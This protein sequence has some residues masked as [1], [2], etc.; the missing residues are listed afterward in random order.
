MTSWKKPT[1]DLVARAIARM[2]FQQQQRYFF[3]HLDNPEWIEPLRKAKFF[4]ELPVVT[5]EEKS[6]THYMWPASRYLARMAALKP[7]LV[8]EI[9]NSFPEIDNPFVIQDILAAADAMPAVSAAKLAPALTRCARG[10]GFIG[11]ERAGRIA[12][13]LAQSEKKDAALVVLRSILEVVPDPRPVTVGPSGHVYRHEARTQIRGFDYGTILRTYGGELASALGS[14]YLEILAKKL[15]KALAEE[16]P[17]Y[18]KAPR[19]VE[20]YSYIWRPHLEHWDMR[21]Q[22]KQFLVFGLLQATERMAAEGQWADAQKVLDNYPFTAYQRVLLFVLAKHPDLDMGLVGK[23]LTDPDLFHALGL[24]QE[25]D[26]LART[27]FPQ[28]SPEVQAAFLALIDAAPDKKQMT[29]R[30]FSDEQIEQICRRWTLE[31]FEPI[32]EGLPPE[33]LKQIEALEQEFGAV[34]KH[35]NH[36]VRGGAVPRGGSSSLSSQDIQELSVDELLSYLRTWTPDRGGNPFGPSYQGLARELTSAIAASPEKYLERLNDFKALQ[37]T[38]VRAAFQGF[39]EATRNGG[40]LAWAPLL[41]LADWICEQPADSRVMTDE[42]DWNGPDRGWHATRFAIVDMLEDALKTNALPP[43]LGDLAWKL[44][45]TL[46][47]DEDSECLAYDEAESQ[48]KDVWT[49]SLNTLRPRAFRVALNYM[50]WLYNTRLKV[51]GA[52]VDDVPDIVTYLDR[53]LD[54]QSDKCLSVR[55]AYG[56][57]LPFL[58]AHAPRWASQAFL[59]IFPPQAEFKPLKDVAWSAYLAANRAYTALF[60]PLEELYREAIHIADADRLQ[61]KSHLQD[62]P[63]SL[64]AHHL[65]QLYWWGKIELAPGG[66][67]NDFLDNV[68]EKALRSAI[69]YVGQ[70]LSEANGAVPDDVISRLQD[71]WDY[72]LAS[73]QSISSPVAFGSFG[74]WFNTQYFNDEWAL[75]HIRRSLL[76]SRGQF[77]PLLNALSRLSNLAN[78]YPA[79]AFDCARMIALASDEYMDL[80]LAELH[81]ILEVALNSGDDELSA[82]VRSFINEL[83]RRGRLSFRALLNRTGVN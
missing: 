17:K 6:I 45:D 65:M 24:R 47:D 50:E 36:T 73:R 39:R 38:Y 13:K 43:E 71:L 58:H 78:D 46:S 2:R 21:E 77:E 69:V 20:D 74:W 3:E 63:A 61:G 28:L 25:F 19:P 31:R 57:K 35:E 67:L 60:L 1:P 32:R 34:G 41:E 42:N 16:Y 9:M 22:A 51:E 68:D 37:T 56:E 55:L 12:A 8:A 52:L 15:L 48:E 66:V 30:G 49:Y 11:M 44:I 72:I 23:K 18:R 5:R 59:R 33:R 64:L 79:M 27:A 81:G 76:L 29:E 26:G 54:P 40:T 10:T 75:D 53:H 4:S 80:W 7:D 82:A 62:R 83:G 14:A 70:S